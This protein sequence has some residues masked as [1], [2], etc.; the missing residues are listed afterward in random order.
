MQKLC[1][2]RTKFCYLPQKNTRLVRCGYN[3]VPIVMKYVTIVKKNVTLQQFFLHLQP[4]IR[5]EIS[6]ICTF[7]SKFR[8]LHSI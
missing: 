3:S 2:N 7:V 8:K 1:F 5:L 6:K 4:I